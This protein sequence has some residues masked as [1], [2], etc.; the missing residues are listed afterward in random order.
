M[1]HA[2]HDDHAH[3]HGPG[4]GHSS[5]EH[6][7]HRD[8]LHDGHLHHVLGDKIEEHRLSVSAGVHGNPGSCTPGHSCMGHEM[9][10]RHG[11]GCG[12]DGVPHGDHVDY[13]VGGHLHHPCHEH[14]D[15]HGPVKVWPA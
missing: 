11:P 2:R 1:N 12:H 14:C 4:C 9:A 13:V 5:I 3:V 7:G 15:D 6:E 8:Y 10:H